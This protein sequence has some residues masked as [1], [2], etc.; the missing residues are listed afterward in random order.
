IRLCLSTCFL[1][2]RGLFAACVLI[3]CGD[4]AGSGR[5]P[6]HPWTTPFWEVARGACRR[7]ARR[8]ARH[9]RQRLPAGSAPTTELLSTALLRS[10]GFC[11][12]CVGLSTERVRA[13]WE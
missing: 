9:W 13:C 2:S 4:G 10:C 1:L 3:G 7:L 6:V 5:W 12:S 8:S 11:G